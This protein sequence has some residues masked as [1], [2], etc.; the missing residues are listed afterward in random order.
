MRQRA[1]SVTISASPRKMTLPQP[2][3]FSPSCRATEAG[4]GPWSLLHPTGQ[5]WPR[6]VKSFFFPAPMRSSRRA[7]CRGTSGFVPAISAPVIPAVDDVAYELGLGRTQ[8]PSRE[9]RLD[10]AERWHDGDFGPDSET[11]KAA[12]STC[13]LCGFYLPIAGSLSAAFGVCGNEYAADGH[14]VHAEYGCGAHS[15]TELPTGAGS[16]QF[17]P[18]DDA[19]LD[20]T[21][22]VP[23]PEAEAETETETTETETAAP[24]ETAAEAED[25]PQ[26]AQS[27]N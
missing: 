7:G 24:T 9:G 6:S 17:D 15:D 14:V 2:T 22:Q 11:A 23:T 18:Y 27:T 12:P 8:V 16:P 13:G 5:M 4:N 1:V 19:A 25:A 26:D 3:V 21:V 20:V 10:A